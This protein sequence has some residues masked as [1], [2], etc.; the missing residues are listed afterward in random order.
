MASAGGAGSAQRR[1][2]GA[3]GRTS[4]AAAIP[5]APAA[6]PA[7]QGA[8]NTSRANRQTDPVTNSP[9]GPLQPGRR[10]IIAAPARIS[11]A[12]AHRAAATFS[13]YPGPTLTTEFLTAFALVLVLEGIAYVFS[14]T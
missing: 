4:G 6:P 5:S 11:V 9:A 8:E 13:I 10:R 14:P 3:P 1:S 12:A 2:G 7:T